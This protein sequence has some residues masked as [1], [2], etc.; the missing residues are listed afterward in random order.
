[1]LKII[2]E[3]K[4]FFEDCYRDIN[5]RGYARI[6]KISAPTA[7]TVLKKYSSEGLLKY[8]EDKG[9]LL[10]RA[11]RESAI[12]RDLSKIYWRMKLKD[13]IDYLDDLNV[14]FV[15]LFGSISKLEN[16]KLSDIDL[17]ISSN[18]MIN[19]KHYENILKRKIQIFSYKNINDIKN[20][21]L[22]NNILNGHILLGRLE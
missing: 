13:L 15:I 10:F 22:K 7:S 19:V 11:N 8:E 21:E 3:L 5:V 14:K 4:P 9:Y 1:M 18:K 17:F 2:N 16:N 12:L 6:Q 20:K